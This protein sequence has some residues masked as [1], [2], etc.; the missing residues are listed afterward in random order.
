MKKGLLDQ[1]VELETTHLPLQRIGKNKQVM[2]KGTLSLLKTP[3][4]LIL[5]K[6][7]EQVTHKKST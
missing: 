6:T 3:F 4:S 5:S 1:L 2:R 7:T